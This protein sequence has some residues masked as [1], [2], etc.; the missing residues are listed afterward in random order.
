MDA[1]TLHQAGFDN[2]I[3]CLGTAFTGEM[4]HL[5]ARY[6]DEILLCYDSDEAGQK[7][8]SLI[9]DE[10]MAAMGEQAGI[11][12]EQ[13]THEEVCG[14]CSKEIAA[15]PALVERIRQEAPHLLPEKA[16][17]EADERLAADEKAAEE[18]QAAID[19]KVAQQVFPE[20]VDPYFEEEQSSGGG[21]GGGGSSA[22]TPSSIVEV[23][24]WVSIL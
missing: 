5:L 19:E 24:T 1:I 20:D 6:S 15:D 18:K 9:A 17:A 23:A 21:G 8:T 4:A 7:A 2:V 10:A 12:I 3:A 14:N 16:A 11:I 22:V 13:L